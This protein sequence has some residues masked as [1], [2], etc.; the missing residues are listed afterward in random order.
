MLYYNLEFPGI[1]CDVINVE[2]TPTAL[3]AFFQYLYGSPIDMFAKLSRLLGREDSEHTE[4]S[5]G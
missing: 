4:T 3:G 1:V 2:L 5:K